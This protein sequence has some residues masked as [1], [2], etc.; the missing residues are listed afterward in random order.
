[1]TVVSEQLSSQHESAEQVAHNFVERFIQLEGWTTLAEAFDEHIAIDTLSIKEFTN[2]HLD[3]RAGKE[4]QQVG[5]VELTPEQDAAIMALATELGMQGETNATKDHYDIVTVLGGANQSNLL[6]VRHAKKQM[7]RLSEQG[8]PV[9]YMVLLGSGRLLTDKEKEST[10]NYAP[11]AT[12][13]FDLLNGALEHEFGVSATDEKVIELKNFSSKVVGEQ[14]KDFWKVRSYTLPSGTEVLSVSAPQVVGQ[15]RVN[16][17][18]TVRFMNEVMGREML[19]G[20]DVLNVTTDLYVDFQHPD[21]LRYLSLQSGAKV[22]TIGYGGVDRPAATYGQEINSAANQ[23]QLLQQE[24][25]LRA[26]TERLP[27]EVQA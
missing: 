22:E 23:V 24:L 12:T 4:R 16:T 13:E 18:D 7:D 5:T 9:P 8:N 26:S 10:A 11:G 2:K 6:R 20:K 3:F 15:R 17:E 25:E 1:M 14:D 27:A 21:L 19:D